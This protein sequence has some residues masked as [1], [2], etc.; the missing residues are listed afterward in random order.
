MPSNLF[1]ILVFT[2]ILSIIIFYVVDFFFQLHSLVFDLFEIELHDIFIC[3]A[4]NLMTRVLT[5]R[6]NTIMNHFPPHF[7]LQFYHFTLF[8]LKKFDFV[9]TFNFFSIG[10]SRSHYLY[11]EFCKLFLDKDF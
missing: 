3:Y 1:F 6:V 7:L 5:L 4:F 2:L 8:F 11:H 10:L 9:A